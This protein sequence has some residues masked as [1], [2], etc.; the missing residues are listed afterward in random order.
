[1]QSMIR[2]LDKMTDGRGSKMF[3]FKFFPTSTSID[4]APRAPGHM[5]TDPWHRAGHPPLCFSQP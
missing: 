1:M 5:F 3:L 4:Q 2:L